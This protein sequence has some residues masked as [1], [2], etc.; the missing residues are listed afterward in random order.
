[1]YSKIQ[2]KNTLSTYNYVFLKSVR[3]SQVDLGG[4]SS[5]VLN[6]GGV[7]HVVLNHAVLTTLIVLGCTVSFIWNN[8]VLTKL[9]ET[10]HRPNVVLAGTTRRRYHRDNLK[11][12][13]IK[14]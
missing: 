10:V 7:I 11:T 14:L 6:S 12:S 9:S 8:A 2:Y 13:S 4:M 3:T 1:V 5:I